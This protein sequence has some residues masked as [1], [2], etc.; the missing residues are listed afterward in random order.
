MFL[1]PIIITFIVSLIA[2]LVVV[3]DYRFYSRN[4]RLEEIFSIF[5]PSITVS[6]ITSLVWFLMEVRW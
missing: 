2:M 5:L 3:S 1:L 4:L 6:G